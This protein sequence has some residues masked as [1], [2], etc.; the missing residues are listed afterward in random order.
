[1]SDD[2]KARLLAATRE[3][4]SQTRAASRWQTWL[5]SAI[6]VVAALAMFFA[7]DGVRHGQGR[8]TWFYVSSAVG[9]ALM[10]TASIWMAWTRGRSALGRPFAWLIGVAV[11][12]PVALFAMM[13]AFVAAHPEVALVHPERIG[14]RCLDLTL[15]AGAFPLVG[16]T[17]LRRR[18]DP[19]HPAAT[20]AALGA[21]CG[22]F[23]GVMVEVWCPVATPQHVAIGHILPIVILAIAGFVLGSTFIG[24]RSRSR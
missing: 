19:V 3:T 20:G 18:S 13:L 17:F 22:A 16:F 15:A 21:A 7:A 8:P 11:G 24:M 10:T 4:R 14:F 12:T 23:A 1:V 9:W 5:I 6:S 2:L